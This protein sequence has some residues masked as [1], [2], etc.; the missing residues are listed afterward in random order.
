[1]VGTPKSQSVQKFDIWY[2][3][4]WGEPLSIKTKTSNNQESD[5]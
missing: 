1:M 4:E 3:N 5:K 2:I